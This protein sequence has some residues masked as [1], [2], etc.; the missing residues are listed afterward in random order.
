[1]KKLVAFNFE[2]NLRKLER[3]SAKQEYS[4]FLD[5]LFSLINYDV[6]SGVK[7]EFN[8]LNSFT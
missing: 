2:K 7:H 5:T 4:L 3:F 6:Y 1:M 8:S